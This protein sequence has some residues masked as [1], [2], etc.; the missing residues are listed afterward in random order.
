[1]T[2]REIADELKVSQPTVVNYLSEKKCTLKKADKPKRKVTQYK[3]S[4]YTKPETA[5]KKIIEIFGQ[6]YIEKMIEAFEKTDPG[7]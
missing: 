1:M 2:Q 7:R 3:I 4:Q 5:V 6:E